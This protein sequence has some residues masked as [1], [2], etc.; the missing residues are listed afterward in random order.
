[1]YKFGQPRVSP[2]T[3]PACLLP[4]AHVS[5]QSDKYN[6]IQAEAEQSRQLVKTRY[7]EAEGGRM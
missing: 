6:K 4:I 3:L 1:M 5:S 2:L 7:I